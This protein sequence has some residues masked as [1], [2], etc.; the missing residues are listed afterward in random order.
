[1]VGV[2]ARVIGRAGDDVGPPLAHCIAA[3]ISFDCTPACT[4]PMAHGAGIP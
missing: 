2:G 1:V 3:L 4:G